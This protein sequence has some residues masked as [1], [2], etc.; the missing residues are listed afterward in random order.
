MICAD[1]SEEID[2]CF[3]TIKMR[4]GLIYAGATNGVVYVFSSPAASSSGRCRLI[5]QLLA[6]QS[7]VNS[8]ALEGVRQSGVM[9]LLVTG[10][11]DNAI[12]IYLLSCNDGG[13]DE[14]KCCVLDHQKLRNC[15]SGQV[16][17]LALRVGGSIV[18]NIPFSVTSVSIDQRLI[19]WN[20]VVERNGRMGRL[21]AV[22]CM[23]TPVADVSWLTMFTQQ[24]QQQQTLEKEEKQQL[25]EQ[26]QTIW[27]CIGGAG[28]ASYHIEL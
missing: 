8:M 22:N 19:E 25:Q 21:H 18:G 11:D 20:S 13:D 15:H 17:G 5:R 26:Q 4:G 24:Q 14:E 9:N 10:G 16:T 1:K 2:N 12:S 28:L 3:L 7:G 6:H 27:C 23:M